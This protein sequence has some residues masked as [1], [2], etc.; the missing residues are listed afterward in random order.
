MTGDTYASLGIY[1]FETEKH[2]GA[3]SDCDWIGRYAVEQQAK[4]QET[5]ALK[6]WAFAAT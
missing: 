4:K 6:N 5:R 1:P 2:L 3:V